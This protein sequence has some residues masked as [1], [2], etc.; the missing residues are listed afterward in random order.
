MGWR[1]RLAA[2]AFVVLAGSAG[3]GASGPEAAAQR[4]LDAYYV[5]ADLGEAV[6]LVDGLALEK[7]REQQALTRG[8]RADALS[9][10]RQVFYELRRRRDRGEERVVFMYDLRVQGD[11]GSLRKRA[12]ITVA[13]IGERWRVTNFSDTDT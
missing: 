6:K 10:K 12:L 9:R 11:G 8:I 1:G 7:V 4:F 3:C 13:R 5:Q 2:V